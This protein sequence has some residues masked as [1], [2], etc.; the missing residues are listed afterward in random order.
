M[1]RP[2]LR[3]AAL[4]EDECGGPACHNVQAL[5]DSDRGR[6]DGDYLE[7]PRLLGGHLG[8]KASARL[9]PEESDVA[10]WPTILA[11]KQCLRRP[12]LLRWRREKTVSGP[13]LPWPGLG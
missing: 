7:A 8:Q 9:L 11:L 12:S 6:R 5:E 3:T 4:E 1:W 10:A 13:S 2:G